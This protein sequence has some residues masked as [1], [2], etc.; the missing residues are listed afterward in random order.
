MVNQNKS[1]LQLAT[2]CMLLLFSSCI[3]LSSMQTARTTPKGE[4]RAGLS[5]V[6]LAVDQGEVQ[7]Y[8]LRSNPTLEAWTRFGLKEDIDFGVKFGV[9]SSSLVNVDFKWQFLGD[10]SSLFAMGT[11]L[12]TGAGFNIGLFDSS[13]FIYTVHLPLYTSI[14][15]SEGLAIFLNPQV[16]FHGMGDHSNRNYYGGSLGAFFGKKIKI[17]VE[18]SFFQVQELG[19]ERASASL[20][21]GG[22]GFVVKI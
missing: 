14:H 7:G 3:S 16:I 13:E 11:G 21:Q 9:G 10:Q 12:G 19:G 4:T 17:C 22:L 5:V 15:P 8:S 18:T 2:W 1:F 6:G 20:L